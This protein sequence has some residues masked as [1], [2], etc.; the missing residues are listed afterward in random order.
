MSEEIWTAERKALAVASCE[1]WHGTKHR[2]RMCQVGV[3]VDC[4]QFVKEVLADSGII[5]PVAFGSYDVNDGTHNVSLRLSK[6]ISFALDVES[7]PLEKVAFGD[8]AIFR[9]GTRSGHVGFCAG[10]AIWHALAGQCVT[11]SQFNL[12][13]HEIEFLYRIK[14][15]GLKNSPTIAAKL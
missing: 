12:W 13:R 8:L 2:N 14:T 1:K 11:R 10:N 7:V 4:I 6:A 3:G 15:L 9:T 5:E